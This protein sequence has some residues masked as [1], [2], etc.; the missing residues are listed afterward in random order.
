[1]VAL[2]A[3]KRGRIDRGQQIATFRQTQFGRDDARNNHKC[4]RLSVNGQIETPAA[5]LA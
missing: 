2:Q 5:A 4:W 1:M 3:V